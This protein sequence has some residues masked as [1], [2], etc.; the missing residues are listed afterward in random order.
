MGGGGD[1]VEN[2]FGEKFQLFEKAL[3]SVLAWR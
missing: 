1:V 2:A 3:I